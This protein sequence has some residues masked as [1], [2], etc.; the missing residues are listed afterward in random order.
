MTSLLMM[1][2]GGC[3]GLIPK[4]AFL[5][6][7]DM[8]WEAPPMR[9]LD[10][11]PLANGD[12]GA[13]IWGDGTPLCFTL[14]KYDAWE[15]REHILTD[16]DLTYS[17]LR[18]MVEQKQEQEAVQA[19]T[20][21][22]FYNDDSDQLQKPFPTRL[23]MPRL[24]IDFGGPIE[25]QQARLNLRQATA[26]IEGLCN[27]D[28]MRLSAYTHARQNLLVIQVEGVP[29]EQI[30]VRLRFDHLEERARSLLK[31]WGYPDPEIVAEPNQGTLR[32]TAPTG[33][34]YAV[35]W[36]KT[37]AEDNRSCTILV[38]IAS[39]NEADDPLA[40]GRKRVEQAT[41]RKQDFGGHRRWWNQYWGR[42]YLAIPDTR[43]ESLY[44][45]EMYKL[46]CSSRPGKWPVTLQGLWT[47]DGMMPPWSGDYHLDMNVQES[48]WPIYTANR[49]EL[50][51]PLYRVFSAC[52]PRWKQ[53]CEQFFKFEGIWAGCAI[54]PRGE[55]VYG[56]TGVEF[57][58]GNTAWLAHLYWLHWLY[59]QDRQFLREQAL[60]IIR[61]SFLTYANLLEKGDDGRL[62]VPLSY[63]PEYH[64]GNFASFVKNP[65][66]DLALI[67]WLGQSILAANA[68]L[69]EQDPLT[70]R[71]NQTL[72]QL[73]D[74][75]RDSKT[76][77]LAIAEGVPLDFSHRHFSHLMAIHPLGIMTIDNPQEKALIENSLRHIVRIGFG[78]WTGWSFPWMSLIAGRT[79]LGNM[80]WKMLDLYTEA[81]INQ[82]TLHVNGDPRIYGLSIHNYEP[83]T[84]EG[85]SAAAAA[86]MEMLIQSNNEIIRVFPALPDRWNDA[87]FS[88][89][90][91]EGAF[92]VTS[93]LVDGR[94]SF[95]DLV[96]ETGNT[97]VLRNPW[98]QGAVLQA[99][100]PDTGDPVGD[101]ITLQG[102][103]VQFA[104]QPGGRYLLYPDDRKP[105]AHDMTPLVFPRRGNDRNIFGIKRHTVQRDQTP[106]LKLFW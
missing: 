20:S 44:Y 48:Y 13:M 73:V 68:V 18:K 77:S 57:W 15:T 80:S 45:L 102:W 9:W 32:L 11:I 34:Q 41:G 50:G 40:F 6:A 75:P 25:W 64:E 88:G 4:P 17:V 39:S 52:I 38:T 67:R 35:C 106:A 62:H 19:L 87:Y 104:T 23:P 3:L 93:K 98:G 51:E 1:L 55:R 53:Q 95:I 92:L 58:P 47:S 85:G 71:V 101:Q 27:Q 46:G 21:G 103:Q 63:S 70:D 29:A 94:I 81:F 43:L 83:M 14:D 60:P 12:I 89:L 26:T 31:K 78:R 82:N 49:L 91:T 2:A 69:G 22:R 97:C 96:S 42:S 90:R 33:Y 30:N 7:H 36:Q 16:E 10:G 99:L 61:L 54:G 59:S 74:Y 66:V 65:T 84:I 86:I 100:D 37:I 24:E 8:I 105:D 72:E 76:G 28:P 79:H 5:D 56:Y